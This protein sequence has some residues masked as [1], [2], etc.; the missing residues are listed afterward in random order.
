ML[1]VKGE[2]GS[3]DWLIATVLVF[4][5]NPTVGE[6]ILVYHTEHDGRVVVEFV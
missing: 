6:Q 1:V 2:W 3:S 4:P 5:R